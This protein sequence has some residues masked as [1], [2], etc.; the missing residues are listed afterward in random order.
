MFFPISPREWRKAQPKIVEVARA[1][2]WQVTEVGYTKN[3]DQW[4][5]LSSVSVSKTREVIIADNA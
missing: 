4:N 3:N 2:F 5:I 1:Q